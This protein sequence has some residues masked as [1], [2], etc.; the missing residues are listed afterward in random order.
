MDLLVDFSKVHLEGLRNKTKPPVYTENYDEMTNYYKSHRIQKTDPITFAELKEETCF[1]YDKMWNPYNGLILNN[2]PFGPLCFSP[3]TIVSHIY[4]TRLNNLWISESDEKDGV[5][6]GYYG[7]GV[8]AGEEFELIN[9]GNYPERYIFR[10]PIP[11]CYLPEEHNMNTITFGPKFTNQDITKLDT[12]MNNYHKSN[13]IY[14]KIGSLAN[15]KRYYDVAIS[16]DPLNLDLD[17]LNINVELART[18]CIP[19]NFIN[20]RAVDILRDM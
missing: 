17:G 15:L 14:K 20:R 3:D 18:Q 4:Y 2:D 12:L 8:G 9:R 13:D 16:K 6:S 10:L 11:N 7:D 19:N 5:Y 1:S